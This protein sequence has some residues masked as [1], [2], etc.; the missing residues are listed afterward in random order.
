MVWR[1]RSHSCPLIPHQ[2]FFDV[3]APSCPAQWIASSPETPL[4]AQH[5]TGEDGAP[6]GR[7]LLSRGWPKP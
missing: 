1:M 6:R 3:M 7:L 5:F 2:Q 4:A